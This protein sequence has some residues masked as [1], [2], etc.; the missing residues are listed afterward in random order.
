MIRKATEKILPYHDKVK[1]LDKQQRK[2]YNTIKDKYPNLS[3]EDMKNQII[4]HVVKIDD[5][6]KEQY[7]NLLK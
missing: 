6:Y 4:P 1:D 5:K 2:L 7:K 3:D